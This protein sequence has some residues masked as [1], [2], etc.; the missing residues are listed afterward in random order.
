LHRSASL[1]DFCER[2][3]ADLVPLLGGGAAGF[4]IFENA[5]GRL[6]RIA[7]YLVDQL[8]SSGRVAPAVSKMSLVALTEAQ[9]SGLQS[10][11]IVPRVAV[12]LKRKGA[13]ALV[14]IPAWRTESA[15]V[16]G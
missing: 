15:I 4:Y 8:K 2:F 14:E 10:L 11:T 12:E 9:A 6:R 5:R 13:V 3:L 16:A 1:K 7:A